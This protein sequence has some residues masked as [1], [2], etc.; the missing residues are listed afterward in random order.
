MH[1]LN[2]ALL[3]TY[4]KPLFELSVHYHLWIQTQVFSGTREC[5][6]FCISDHRSQIPLWIAGKLVTPKTEANR[7]GY[8][9]QLNNI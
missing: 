6:N 3:S 5:F 9:L 2:Q 7:Y 8:I 4:L 1:V